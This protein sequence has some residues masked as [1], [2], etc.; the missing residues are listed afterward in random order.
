MYMYIY[1]YVFVYIHMY[2]F[3]YIYIY[4]YMYI[5]KYRLKEAQNTAAMLTTFQEID[6]TNLIAMRTKYKEEFEKIHNVKLG[7][8]SAF[9]RYIFFYLY[10][11]TYIVI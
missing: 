10:M 2:V 6:M 4:M 11:Y 3:I 5:Y 9:V 1:V 7:F 8:M